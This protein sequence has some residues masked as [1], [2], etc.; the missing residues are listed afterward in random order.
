MTP[1]VT[2]PSFQSS[3]TLDSIALV[4]QM[5]ACAIS[6]REV[7]HIDV[8]LKALYLRAGLGWIVGDQSEQR[9]EGMNAADEK[10]MFEGPTAQ[11]QLASSQLISGLF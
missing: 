11:G 5:I 10:L 7:K 1:P 2:R 8:S 6:L 4:R 9:D 3:V